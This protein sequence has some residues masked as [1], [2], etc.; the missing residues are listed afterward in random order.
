[1]RAVWL[2]VLALLALAAAVALSAPRAAADAT[3][4][5]GGNPAVQLVATI[6]SPTDLLR[7]GNS[8]PLKVRVVDQHGVPMEG[9]SVTAVAESGTISPERATTDASGL[10]RFTY[11][12]TVTEAREFRIMIEAT[13]GT[14][15]PDV[16][17][18]T[19]TVLPAIPQK[20]VL[21]RP[22]TA[23]SAGIGAALLAAIASTEFG[24]YGLSNLVFFPLYSRLKKE[25]V[26]DHFVRGQ[27]YG[28][29]AAH[30]GEHY[31][32]L[33]DAL[34]VTNGTL[35][36]HLHTLEIQGFVKSLRDGIY[37]RFYPVEMSIPR[38]KGIRLSDLQE[39][40]LVLIRNDGGPTQQ[41]IADRLCVSQQTVSYN[42][43]HLSREGLIR[44]EKLGRTK[45]YF[46][47]E[48]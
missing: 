37:K 1:M 15:I 17:E 7:S 16:A 33:K 22:E 14:S 25:E 28:Y 10:A 48:T 13:S 26:L 38:D 23:V 44:M 39:H 21:S 47:T 46:P 29:I 36:H 40:M 4:D 43:R 42:L 34:K 8:L 3:L 5:G 18:F 6:E 45:R 32:S 9:V 35:A 41:D 30:P 31:N 24:R 11:T 12:S 2:A 20:P 19:V 27:I